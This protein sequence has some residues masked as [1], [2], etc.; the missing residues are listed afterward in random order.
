MSFPVHLPSSFSRAAI[1]ASSSTT[2]G[3]LLPSH[4]S[5][6]SPPSLTS[7]VTHPSEAVATLWMYLNRVPLLARRVGAF[8]AERRLSNSSSSMR[9]SMVLVSERASMRMGSPS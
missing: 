4:L 3:V 1:L 9:T 6:P 8:H 5:T 7:S 2:A